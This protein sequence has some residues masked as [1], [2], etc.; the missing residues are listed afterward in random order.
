MA[1]FTRLSDTFWSYVSPRK[2]VAH[3]P[4]PKTEPAFKRPRVSARKGSLRDLKRAAKSMSPTER[5]DS[6]RATTPASSRASGKRKSTFPPSQARGK[7]RGG[8]DS[9]AT[10]VVYA[11]ESEASGEDEDMGDVESEL[12]SL[13]TD[14]RVK[15]P[16]PTPQYFLHDS[17]SN[18]DIDDTSVVDDATYH[19]TPKRRKLVTL[20]A[21]QE[22]F[23]VSSNEL[24]KAG[25]DDDHIT[26][27]QK[28]KL[29]GHEPLFP[30]HWHF[31]F[32]FMPDALFAEDD[33]AFVSS[34]HADHFKAEKALEALLDL[35]SRMRDSIAAQASTSLEQYARKAINAYLKWAAQDSGL[36]TKATIPVLEIVTG[37]AS[38]PAS[39]LQA[40]AQRKLARLASRYRTAFRVLQSTE[41]SPASKASTQYAYPTPTLYALIASHTLV[42]LV[43]FR[44]EDA[45]AGI[46]PVAFFDFKDRD[47]DAWNSLALAI[48]VCHVRNVQVR[49][50]EETGLGARVPGLETDA[51]D[52]EEDPDL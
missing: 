13:V 24:R 48:A 29:R 36:D 20:P 27:V 46:R 10:S 18:I 33:D 38:T 42:A 25:W 49:I 16:T 2:P 6:W 4:T 9:R 52:E 17:D 41:S 11:D 22:A 14:M 23:G 43:A 8:N 30:R 21:E 19:S 47:Y 7:M 37:P 44:P 45:N 5:V 3:P 15:S 34:I 32:R 26:L 50:A 51:K 1:L 40:T 12:T 31:S 28:I 35:G 39:Q